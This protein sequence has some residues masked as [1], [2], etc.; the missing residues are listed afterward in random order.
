MMFFLACWDVLKEDI[1]K[2]FHDFPARGKF[3]RKPKYAAF[4]CS[5]F[6]D[7]KGC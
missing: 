3:E 4:N 7:F 5:H 2:V 1:M 6:K